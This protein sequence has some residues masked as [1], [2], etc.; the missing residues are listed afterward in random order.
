MFFTF[1]ANS[2]SC[3]VHSLR[4]FWKWA[5]GLWGFLVVFIALYW[6]NLRPL[7][8]ICFLISLLQLHCSVL[9]LSPRARIVCL[10]KCCPTYLPIPSYIPFFLACLHST[11][12]PT[13]L[14]CFH[15]YPVIVAV[16]VRVSPL[17]S[18]LPKQLFVLKA[19]YSFVKL[20][21]PIKDRKHLKNCN[22]S[23]TIWYNCNSIKI[24][25]FVY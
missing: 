10:E 14:G 5:E 15:G 19:L 8:H 7:V 6:T 13:A 16:H 22:F 18:G 24:S 4:P 23:E 1:Y 12:L 21:Q 25:D 2:F 20:F 11:F 3:A 17:S 9:C